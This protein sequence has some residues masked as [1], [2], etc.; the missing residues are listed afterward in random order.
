MPFPCVSSP[1]LTGAL[2]QSAG[3]QLGTRRP[4]LRKLGSGIEQHPL[5]K[6]HLV[7]RGMEGLSQAAVGWQSGQHYNDEY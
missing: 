4:Q 2:L 3:R 7:N 6:R 5:P 1:L